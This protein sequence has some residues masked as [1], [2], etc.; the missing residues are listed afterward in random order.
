MRDRANY[1]KNR[2]YRETRYISP[3]FDNRGNSK[4][5]GKI[6]PSIKSKEQSYDRER[7]FVESILPVKKWIVETPSFDIHKIINPSA[8]GTDY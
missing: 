3:R 8:S 5:E 7:K 2:R 6:A 4:K 1:R